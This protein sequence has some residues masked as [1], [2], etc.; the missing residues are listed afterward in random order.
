MVSREGDDAARAGLAEKKGRKTEL[1]NTNKQV[2]LRK[3]RINMCSIFL[4]WKL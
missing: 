3:N 2:A 1:S 4:G